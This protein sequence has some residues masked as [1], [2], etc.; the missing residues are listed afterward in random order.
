MEAQETPS[1]WHI[2]C[3]SLLTL[4]AL[5]LRD[6]CCNTLSGAV[7]ALKRVINVPPRKLGA[8]SLAGLD[9]W[10]AGRGQTLSAA[11]FQGCQVPAPRPTYQLFC[12]T[13]QDSTRMSHDTAACSTSMCPV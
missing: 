11:I 5:T 13:V 2:P 12:R 4:F 7:P 6:A 9:A 1:R 3:L 10:A 8:A